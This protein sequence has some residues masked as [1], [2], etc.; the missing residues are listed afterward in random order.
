[1]RVL[2]MHLLRA[3]SM[4]NLV[5]NNLGHLYSRTADPGYSLAVELRSAWPR[6]RSPG[7]LLAPV[8]AGMTEA[9]SGLISRDVTSRGRPGNFMTSN[10]STVS[11]PAPRESLVAVL[12]AP[13]SI[14][15]PLKL[16]FGH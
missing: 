10:S 15:K 5:Q 1:M 11:N 16:F 4:G 14:E 6:Q 7:S 2:K 9:V 13:Q 3:P 8:Y 12:A